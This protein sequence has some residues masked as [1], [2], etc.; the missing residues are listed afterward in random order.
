M[1]DCRNNWNSVLLFGGVDEK[2]RQV[3][4]YG[5]FDSE[6]RTEYESVHLNDVH[7]LDLRTLNWTQ[8]NVPGARPFG[9]LKATS[10]VWRGSLYAVGWRQEGGVVTDMPGRP[11]ATTYTFEMW[12]LALTN[13]GAGWETTPL[14]WEKVR[15]QRRRAV[16]EFSLLLSNTSVGAGVAGFALRRALPHS[17]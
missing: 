2:E 16:I 7:V 13:T 8:L 10:T 5:M 12:R 6:A 11:K 17:R 1:W 4:G 14:A 9:G 15:A 3:G